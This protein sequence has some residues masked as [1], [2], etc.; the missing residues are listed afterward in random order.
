MIPAMHAEP[1]PASGIAAFVAAVDAG[2]LGG[3]AEDLGL[4]QSAVTKRIQALERIAGLPL[5]ERGRH[6]VRP[7]EAG[8]LLYPEAKNALAA[9]GRGADL[10]ARAREARTN[11][12]RIAASHTVGEFLLP[13]WL[14]AFRVDAGAEALRADVQVANSPGVL[15][16]LREGDVELGFV[17][18]IDTLR[19]LE[20]VT[21]MRDELVVVVAAGHRWV[22]RRAVHPRDLE[23]E[24][25]LTRERDSGT[26]AVATAAFA[27]VGVQL[28]PALSTSSIQA[29]KRAVLSGGFTVLS[30]VAIENEVAAGSLRSVRV[31]GVDLSRELR[32]ARV[33]PPARGSAANRLWGWLLRH[34][35]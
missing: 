32:V 13:R 19:D 6:G 16:L 12:I 27:D 8:R 22:S 7:T 1:L 23:S 30:P 35:R 2:T 20:S 25:F 15:A 26:R 17:E 29:L 14:A 34:A 9:L 24:S 5:L 33:G 21:L 4:T 3:A 18:G 10:M 31:A 11:S 28:E